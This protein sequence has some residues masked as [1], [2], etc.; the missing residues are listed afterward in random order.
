[1]AE[2]RSVKQQRLCVLLA[3]AAAI[4]IAAGVTQCTAQLDV[5]EE[6]EREW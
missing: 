5:T 4:G 6:I 2:A 1:M 3:V